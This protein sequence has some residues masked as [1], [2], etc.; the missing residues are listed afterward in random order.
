MQKK[1]KQPQTATL[2]CP[3]SSSPLV[4]RIILTHKQTEL[5]STAAGDILG[6]KVTDA[7]KQHIP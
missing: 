1:K 2:S 7:N 3:D 5:L 4:D 6:Q